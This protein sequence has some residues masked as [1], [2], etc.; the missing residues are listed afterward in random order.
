MC[1]RYFSDRSQF[2]R[3]SSQS[4]KERSVSIRHMIGSVRSPLMSRSKSSQ[5]A[6]VI[7]P[8]LR[9]V[10][11]S[12]R[13]H[14]VVSTR[15]PKRSLGQRKRETHLNSNSLDRHRAG[16]SQF[17]HR[18]NRRAAESVSDPTARSTRQNG[19]SSQLSKPQWH[20]RGAS[21]CFLRRTSQLISSECKL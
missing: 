11:K 6:S 7:Q 12:S 15:Q 1:L 5:L 2:F 4:W 14:A 13:R 20:P 8:K 18:L 9:R 17:D 19:Y 3:S 16:V 21:F 10:M